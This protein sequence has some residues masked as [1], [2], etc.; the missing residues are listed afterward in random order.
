MNPV[1]CRGQEEQD[2]QFFVKKKLL[3]HVI[4]IQRIANES[5]HSKAKRG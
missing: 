1:C 2:E 4:C 3:H 5:E